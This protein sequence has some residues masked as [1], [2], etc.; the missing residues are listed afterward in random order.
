MADFTPINTQEEFDTAI[1][2]RIERER[3]KYADYETVKQNAGKLQTDLDT[4]NNKISELET[5][6]SDLNIK[7]KNY[8]ADNL[9]TK[10]ALKAGIPFEYR[11]RIKGETE[12]E[13]KKDAAQFAELIGEKKKKS[14]PLKQ[15]PGNNDDATKT[16]YKS[17]LSQMFG[18]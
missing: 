8:E 14:P 11:D 10:I 2:D 12:E 13:M 15:E 16:A 5:Q 18:E 9:R 17:M 1:K 7:V 3:A 4:A 6:N